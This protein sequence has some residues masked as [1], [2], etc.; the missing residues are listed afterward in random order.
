LGSL[1]TSPGIKIPQSLGEW[2][3]GPQ[4]IFN[5]DPFLV[6]HRSPHDRQSGS[7]L[8]HFSYRPTCG[9]AASLLPYLSLGN[10]NCLL[11]ATNPV[12][13]SLPGCE[14]PQT[15]TTRAS[16][17]KSCRRPQC[18]HAGVQ[19]NRMLCILAPLATACRT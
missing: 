14:K 5:Y 15:H 2:Q 1:G 10:P 17:P 13:L 7:R 9:S 19:T 8:A 3:L 6:G 12:F 4:H 11:C 16:T 18:T